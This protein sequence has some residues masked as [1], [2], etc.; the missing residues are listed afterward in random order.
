MFVLFS[1]VPGLLARSNGA[2][3][4]ACN[5]LMPQHEVAGEPANNNYFILSDAV[6][7]YTPGQ[8]YLGRNNRSHYRSSVTGVAHVSSF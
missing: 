7:G 8:Q 3:P 5:N 6:N 1:T 4:E 2:P